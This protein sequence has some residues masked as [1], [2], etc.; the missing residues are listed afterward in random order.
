M[1]L[2][3]DHGTKRMIKRIMYRARRY[4]YRPLSWGVGICRGAPRRMPPVSQDA[5]SRV[6]RRRL[7]LARRDLGGH[8]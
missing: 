1:Q 6:F 2:R 5:K 8:I 4:P 7:D 3:D